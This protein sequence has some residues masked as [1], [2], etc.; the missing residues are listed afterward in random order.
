MTAMMPARY[1]VRHD[2]DY[3]ENPLAAALPLR[4]EARRALPGAERRRRPSW[5]LCADPSQTGADHRSATRAGA[6]PH[7]EDSHFVDAVHQS[8]LESYRPRNP[9]ERLSFDGRRIGFV[10]A[11]IT[12]LTWELG[13]VSSA[14]RLFDLAHE[15]MPTLIDHRTFNGRPYLSR[16]L[17]R[18][19]VRL[20][21]T[22]VLVRTCAQIL[23]ATYAAMGVAGSRRVPGFRSLAAMAA[24]TADACNATNLGLLCVQA[25]SPLDHNEACSLW[26]LL[27]YL[28]L[29]CG[30]AL[31]LCCSDHTARRIAMGSRSGYRLLKATCSGFR[32]SR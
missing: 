32:P 27:T 14:M 22:E 16:Q 13:G 30:M 28:Q 31:M 12:L 5:P 25:P 17:V 26:E 11:P 15:S 3:D 8:V 24:S 7:D 6:L 18:L 2:R 4:F 29:R 21:A 23:E 19:T 1:R 10:S 9:L 20:D